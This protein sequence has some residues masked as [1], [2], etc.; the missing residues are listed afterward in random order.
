MG[1]VSAAAS[2]AEGWDPR[3]RHLT[4]AAAGVSMPPKLGI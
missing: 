3:L 4:S 1:H 2:V